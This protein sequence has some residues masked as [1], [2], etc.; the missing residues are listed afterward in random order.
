[1][2]QKERGARKTNFLHVNICGKRG[3]EDQGG[4][5]K[6]RMGIGV[7][8]KKGKADSRGIYPAKRRGL[9]QSSPGG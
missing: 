3:S 7:C 8:K 9:V 5:D 2:R 1:M 4:E 6:E